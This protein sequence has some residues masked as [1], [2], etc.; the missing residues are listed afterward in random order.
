MRED[1]YYGVAG[2]PFGVGFGAA[3][4]DAAWIQSHG[5]LPA[6]YFDRLPEDVQEQV[7]RRA[8][9]R[10]FHSEEEMRRYVKSLLLRA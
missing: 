9:Q 8:A 1:T 6:E 3:S 2:M 5:D 7:N 4:I 10:Q